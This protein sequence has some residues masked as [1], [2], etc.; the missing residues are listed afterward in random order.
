[1]NHSSQGENLV[2]GLIGGMIAANVAGGAADMIT[3]AN[4][5][6][7]SKEDVPDWVKK[8]REERGRTSAGY[9][10]N[11][12]L[13][14]Q[15]GYINGKPVSS[16]EYDAFMSMSEAQRTATYGNPV[17]ETLAEGGVVKSPTRALI[18]EGGEPEVVLPNQK[19]RRLPKYA[20]I[21]WRY[22]GWFCFK[23]PQHDPCWWCRYR[24]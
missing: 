20:K 24:C 7:Q 10:T 23:L 6:Q 21:N 2:G 19:W 9:T 22:A 15:Q 8:N 5:P 17:S 12:D 11:F 13:D 14:T 16:E 4:K 3:G 18:G 1:M